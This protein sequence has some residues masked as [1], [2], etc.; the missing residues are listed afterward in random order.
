MGH[1]SYNILDGNNP[2]YT[3]GK[4]W[5]NNHFSELSFIR[6]KKINEILKEK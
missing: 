1:Y 5:F 2:I 4:D 6:D 3:C